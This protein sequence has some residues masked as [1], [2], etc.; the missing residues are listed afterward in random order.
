MVKDTD[1]KPETFFGEGV[2]KGHMISLWRHPI[3]HVAR[4][5]C[6]VHAGYSTLKCLLSHTASSA[7][8][9][10]FLPFKKKKNSALQHHTVE[11][12]GNACIAFPTVHKRISH[13]GHNLSISWKQV[14][15]PNLKHKTLKRIINSTK[16]WHAMK[17]MTSR[18]HS[19]D[20]ITVLNGTF[21]PVQWMHL[22]T[23]RIFIYNF[24]K[25]ILIIKLMFTHRGSLI[26]P[27]APH[28]Y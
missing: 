21:R 9:P 19:T 6:A 26:Q 22:N 27:D 5:T 16:V 3:K 20:W 13:S 15:K 10:L 17:K 18:A 7:F 12:H 1:K 23:A 28:H 24:I 4:R 11:H 8:T 25:I 14:F 2:K